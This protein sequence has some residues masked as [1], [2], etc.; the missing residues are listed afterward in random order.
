MNELVLE[1]VLEQYAATTPAGNDL[2]ILQSFSEKYPQ[3]AEDLADFAAAR[4]VAKHA[5][6]EELTAEEA[7][8][9]QK[10]GLQ[11]LRAIL[12]ST[13]ELQSLVE[14]AKTKGLNRAK[15]AAAL[16]L[17]TSLVIYLEKRRLAFATIPTKIVT[18]IAE[19]L[20]VT[21]KAVSVYLNQSAKYSADMSF[22]TDTRSEELPPKS[23]AAAVGEDQQL[24]AE[25]KR[26]LLEM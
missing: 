22:K 20:D 4:A 3:F 8:R 14:T 15:F 23:F 2:K 1:E 18:K 26:N 11:N 10:S 21:E 5:P 12:S 16:G 17:S 13:N 6:D 19:V 25:Q 7:K 24:T 9:F